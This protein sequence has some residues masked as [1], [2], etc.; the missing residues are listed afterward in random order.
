MRMSGVSNFYVFSQDASRLMQRLAALV[1]SNRFSRVVTLNPQM[2]VGALSDAALGQFLMDADLCVADGVGVSLL[3]KRL[4]F[5]VH[6]FPGVE[7]MDSLLKSEHQYRV[8]FLGGGPSVNE[9]LI[10]C[11]TQTPYTCRV[12]GAHHGYFSE[13]QWPLIQTQIAQADPD[14]IFVAMGFPKQE[15]YIYALS[16]VLLRGVA[17]GVGGSFDVLSGVVRRAPKWVR[18]C[19]MEWVY[20]GICSPRRMKTWGYMVWFMGLILKGEK[21]LEPTV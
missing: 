8:Y 11:V 13:D 6:T 20:R 17:M 2:V 19:R 4:G 15:Q 14:F 3:A 16:Q 1:Q 12:V 10:S 9:G 7:V 5:S 21:V 18:V